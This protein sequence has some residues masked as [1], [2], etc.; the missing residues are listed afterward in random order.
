MRISLSLNYDN[1][2]SHTA[3]D[4]VNFLR[5]NK[6]HLLKKYVLCA[7]DARQSFMLNVVIPDTNS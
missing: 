5:G 2:T 7:D 1:T 4:D 3:S 6:L